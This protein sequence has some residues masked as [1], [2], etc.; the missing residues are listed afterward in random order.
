MFFVASDTPPSPGNKIESFPNISANT[1]P[2][3]EIISHII[4]E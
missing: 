2:R 1:N 3:A 4:R